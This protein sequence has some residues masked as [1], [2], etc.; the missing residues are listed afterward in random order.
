MCMS[1]QT[2]LPVVGLVLMFCR[3]VLSTPFKEAFFKKLNVCILI[4]FFLLPTYSTYP[5]ETSQMMW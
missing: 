3:V 4:C 5:L 2:S 1:M